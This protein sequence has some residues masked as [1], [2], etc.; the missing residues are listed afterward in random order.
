M[1]YLKLPN[2]T[3]LWVPIINPNMKFMGTLQQSRFWL[4]KVPQRAE[5]L[6]SPSSGLVGCCSRE[7]FYLKDH[8]T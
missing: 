8:G 3:F 4:V 1:K 2:P 5:E 7:E 6:R